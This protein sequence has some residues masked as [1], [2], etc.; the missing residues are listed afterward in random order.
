MRSTR[1]VLGARLAIDKLEA[2]AA[3]VAGPVEKLGDGHAGRGKACVCEH[4]GF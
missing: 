2:A 1:G 3:P 4:G